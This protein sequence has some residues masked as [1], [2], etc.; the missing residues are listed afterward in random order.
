MR[1]KYT[2]VSLVSISF[3]IRKRSL[4][5]DQKIWESSQACLRMQATVAGAQTLVCSD[6]TPVG[7]APLCHFPGLLVL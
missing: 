2:V 3:P 6:G 7:Q 5:F 4:N 1:Y